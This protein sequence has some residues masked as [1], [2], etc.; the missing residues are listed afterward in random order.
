MNFKKQITYAWAVGILLSFMSSSSVIAQETTE[1]TSS[2]IDFVQQERIAERK[3]NIVRMM[4]RHWWARL[5]LQA[6]G[7]VGLLFA[8][9]TTLGPYVFSR[10][11]SGP[12]PIQDLTFNDLEDLES[13]T[14]DQISELRGRI[15]KL[16]MRNKKT[17]QAIAKAFP[18][19]LSMQWWKNK[20]V[21]MC[22][23]ALL[24]SVMWFLTDK[25]VGQFFH[26]D[27]ISWFA[28]NHTKIHQLCDELQEY[29]EKLK[30]VKD[31]SDEQLS[32]YRQT[33][34]GI[35]RALVPHV[36]SV[37]AFMEYQVNKFEYEGAVLTD[38][39]QLQTP[40]LIA[41]S[42]AFFASMNELLP[43]VDSLD[44][45]KDSLKIFAQFTTDL[46]LITKRFTGIE[47][48][49]EWRMLN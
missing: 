32:Y 44:K 10:G 16:E 6:G 8:A 18:A 34:I 28:Q 20:T 2:V 35:C 30:D 48:C 15:E 33:L 23:S 11:Q 3:V 39:E 45:L 31:I 27:S 1:Q 19:W 26:E 29:S 36:E 5:G 14:P 9:Y 41:S 38:D 4:N 7:A 40:H 49:I 13:D 17:G 25:L 37:A 43:S 47:N 24:S 21:F 12:P 42:N 22:E 46:K